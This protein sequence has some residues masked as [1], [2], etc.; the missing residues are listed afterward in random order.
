MWKQ[1]GKGR[2][3]WGFGLGF[4]AS[5]GSWELSLG[6]ERVRGGGLESVLC[7]SRWARFWAKWGFGLG[8]GASLG[9]WELSLRAERV[10]G[11]G[12]ESMLCGS[13]WARFWAK[14]GF[15]LGIG[16]SLGSWEL[17]LGAERVRGGGLESVLCGSRW[18]RGGRGGDSGWGLGLLWAAGN[19]VLGPRGFGVVALKAYYVGA[20]G[21]GEGMA[22]Q[23]EGEGEVGMVGPQLLR[24][25]SQDFLGGDGRVEGIVVFI[26]NFVFCVLEDFHSLYSSECTRFVG[27]RAT[28]GGSGAHSRWAP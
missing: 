26:P 21:Q 12:L 27:R 7:G 19:L 2:A 4:G 15:G 3:R 14:W 9:S 24:G 1:V 22:P 13:R 5:L 28:R 6:A 25:S 11:G 18:A 20:G 16:A 23:E 17:S 10:R 8:F